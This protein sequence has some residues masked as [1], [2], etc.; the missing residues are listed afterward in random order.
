MGAD[1]RVLRLR[2][3]G[4]LL[5][6]RRQGHA[7]S[8]AQLSDPM[9]RPLAMSTDVLIVGAGP[10]GLTLANL[11]GSVGVA[12]MLVEARDTTSDLPRAIVLDDEGARTLQACGLS[13]E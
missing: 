5:R 13:R 2:P 10:T 7:Q 4:P 9:A 3:G 11:L 8:E 6:Y 12:T 1:R